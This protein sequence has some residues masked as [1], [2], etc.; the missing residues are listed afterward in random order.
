M[1][2][3]ILE[4]S[5]LEGAIFMSRRKKFIIFSL[6]VL[7]ILSVPGTAL[8]GFDEYGYNAK[9]RKFKGTLENWENLVAWASGSSLGLQSKK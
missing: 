8:A 2:R 4:K 3:I 6:L 1:E 7:I 5:V 9:A